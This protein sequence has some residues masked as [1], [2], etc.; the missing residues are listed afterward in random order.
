MAGNITP[1]LKAEVVIRSWTGHGEGGKLIGIEIKCDL[2]DAINES[3]NVTETDIVLAAELAE[4]INRV[5][6]YGYRNV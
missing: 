5:L 1:P 3:R 2:I 4:F 6:E